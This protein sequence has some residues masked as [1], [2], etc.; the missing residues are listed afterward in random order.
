MHWRTPPVEIRELGNCIVITI[1]LPRCQPATG[2]QT[3][4][5]KPITDPRW[6]AF[7][8][9]V[10]RIWDRTGSV[11]QAAKE[12][13]TAYYIAHTIIREEKSKRLQAERQRIKNEAAALA[14]AG[15]PLQHIAA[16]VRKSTRTIRR[17]LNGQ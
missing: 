9:Q 3:P 8:E 4:N 14:S 6:V 1:R 13:K 5:P 16:T 17:W 12:N 11:S 10:T 2:Y 15:Y 7:K